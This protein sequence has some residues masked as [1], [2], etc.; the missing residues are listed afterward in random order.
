MLTISFSNQGI[1]VCANIWQRIQ[2]RKQHN[3]PL[4]KNRKDM[5]KYDT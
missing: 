4:Y 3:P 1:N 5:I 2:K